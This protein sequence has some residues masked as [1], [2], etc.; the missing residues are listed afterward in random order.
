M[1][2][3]KWIR[4]VLS[5]F[6]LLAL[7]AVAA[8]GDDDDDDDD[9]NGNGDRP[10]GGS[11]TVHYVEFQSWDPHYSAFAQDI[12]HQTF[13]WRGMYKI[14]KDNN[15]VPEMAASMPE[16]SDDGLTY[17]I[18]LQSGLQWSDGDDLKASDFVLGIHRTCNPDNAGQYQYILSN[19]VGCDDYYGAT[20]ATDAEKEALRAAVGVEAVDDTT[21]RITVQNAQPTFTMLLALWMTWPV[22]EHI[23][24]DPGADWLSP[25]QMVYNGP[26]KVQAYTE[27]ETMVFVRNEHYAGAHAAYLDQ[28]TF[29][30]IED[31]AQANNAFRSGE[32][33][34]ALADT[35]NLNSLQSEFPNDLYSYQTPTTIGIEMQMNDEHLANFDL[36]LAIS[37]A[38]DRDTLAN[39]VLQGAVIPSTTW[40]P[41]DV[42]G[43]SGPDAFEDQ[44]GYDPEAAAESI[45]R[46]GYP[47][48]AGVPPLSFIIRDT[49]GNRAMAEF[50]QQEYREIIGV[51]L[52][53]EVLDAPT[54]SRRFLD[55]Q[56]QLFPGGWHQ[57][58][59]DPENWI[60]GL[61]DTGGGLNKYN[62]SDP[63]IDALVEQAQYNTNNEQRLDQ[64]RQINELVSTRLCGIA[65]IYHS[66]GHI[67]ISPKLKGARDFATSQDRLL[68][69]DWAPEEWYLE[70]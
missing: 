67:L 26:F 35:A 9:D 38:T 20:E 69:G 48:G 62:C 14:D 42:A 27:G 55:E 36:R 61:F 64:Y 5:A 33:D 66:A 1:T 60:L 65:V 56:F 7:V 47:N 6:A 4:L 37:Q 58:F 44:I 8:C 31:T 3:S 34:M 28:I 59:P 50:L 10:T 54:R 70:Q 53:I 51:E 24:P 40:I 52:N 45:A 41:S 39:V 13:V 19:I 32:L 16:I 49:P 68:A 21:V 12:G 57:D 30:Y 22:P 11:I 18:T 23:L 17:T 25:T 43:I 2:K 29:R 46:A 15:P 63:D